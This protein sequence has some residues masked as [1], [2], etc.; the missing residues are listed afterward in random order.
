MVFNKLVQYNILIFLFQNI[1][2]APCSNLIP[3]ADKMA[4]GWNILKTDLSGLFQQTPQGYGEYPIMDFTCNNNQT[5]RNPITGNTFG[6]P[7]QTTGNVL[8]SG[9][10]YS[11]SSTFY[12]RT[13]DDIYASF[14]QYVDKSFLFGM[15]GGSSSFNGW[16]HSILDKSM[17][18]GY[19]YS[20]VNSYEI[21]MNP[22]FRTDIIKLSKNAEYYLNTSLSNCGG[23]ILKYECV[24][25]FEKF[26]DMFGTHRMVKFSGGGRFIMGFSTSNIYASTQTNMQLDGNVNANFLNIIGSRVGLGGSGRVVNDMWLKYTNTDFYCLGGDGGCP[27]NNTYSEWTKRVFASPWVN[28]ANFVSLSTIMP[29]DFKLTFDLA[30]F[31][32]LAKDYLTKSQNVLQIF[33]NKLGTMFM[34]NNMITMSMCKNFRGSSQCNDFILGPPR[35][36]PYHPIVSC[37]SNLYTATD[38]INKFNL[39]IKNTISGLKNTIEKIKYINQHLVPQLDF[40]S[41][42]PTINNYVEMYFNTTFSHY[43]TINCENT[44]YCFYTSGNFMINMQEG[45]VCSIPCLKDINI[46]I[47]NKN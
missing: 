9:G 28:G 10:S 46:Y 30:V 29:D 27:N 38:A 20:V 37:V 15:F 23:L 33:V 14:S 22:D 1:Y 3:G 41:L 21:M 5:W 17:T 18:V 47:L 19:S 25:P 24:S 12:Y 31:N 7:D 39:N 16:Y 2:S 32:Y 44:C 11:Q 42:V 35:S 36:E 43:T 13:F 34:N 26:F 45:Q 4:I 40:I 6:L 8:L